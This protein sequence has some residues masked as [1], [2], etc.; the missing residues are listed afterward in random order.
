MMAA[1]G[2][3]TSPKDPFLPADEARDKALKYAEV[4]QIAYQPLDIDDL[5]E[6]AMRITDQTFDKLN[7]LRMVRLEK[8]NLLQ[9]K[10]ADLKESVK[11]MDRSKEQLAAVDKSID[12]LHSTHDLLLDQNALDMKNIEVLSI[13]KQGQDEVE[14]G[15]V[16]TDYGDAIFIPLSIINE[17]NV[18]IQA[19]GDEKVKVLEKTLNFRKKINFMNWEHEYLD[20]KAKNADAHYVDL[21]LLRVNKQLKQIISGVKIE[22]DRTKMEKAEVRESDSWSEAT[23]KALYRLPR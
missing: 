4:E 14:Q 15:A 10:A 21:Q 20:L 19:L 17:T 2:M 22:S 12:A 16:A 9:L 6:T 23:A 8:E 18:D 1:Q 13:F 7:E 11:H 5:P 3:W